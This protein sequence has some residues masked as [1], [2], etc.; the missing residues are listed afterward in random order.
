MTLLTVD[1]AG[2]A[3]LPAIWGSAMHVIS[4]KAMHSM[5]RSLSRKLPPGAKLV[6]H[7]HRRCSLPFPEGDAGLRKEAAATP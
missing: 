3:C 5:L 7:E 2:F 6:C 4:A 1:R